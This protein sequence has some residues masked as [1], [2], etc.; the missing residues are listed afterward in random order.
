MYRQLSLFTTQEEEKLMQEVF[1][2][3]Y[4]KASMI[5]KDKVK[6]DGSTGVFLMDDCFLME[7]YGSSLPVLDL[8]DASQVMEH[9]EMIQTGHRF[10]SLEDAYKRF[11]GVMEEYNEKK[12]SIDELK[13]KIRI[14][15]TAMKNNSMQK[16]W[17][18]KENEER[19]ERNHERMKRV[20]Q[21]KKNKEVKNEEVLVLEEKI[22]ELKKT[23]FPHEA[24]LKD[25]LLR[26]EEISESM[27]EISIDVTFSNRVFHPNKYTEAVDEMDEY[28]LRFEELKAI[29]VN[30]DLMIQTID[31]KIK[32]LESELNE[33]KEF[34]KT[35]EEHLQENEEELQKALDERDTGSKLVLKQ[36][37]RTKDAEKKIASMTRKISSIE[38][39]MEAN[40][41]AIIDEISNLILCYVH[42]SKDVS[43]TLCTIK[44]LYEEG[45]P[46]SVEQM[47]V[48]VFTT[49]YAL[50]HSLEENYV[51][52][53][54]M[55]KDAKVSKVQRK[56]FLKFIRVD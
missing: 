50:V 55:A 45:K 11:E 40:K 47:Q 3:L 7:V 1:D 15:Q 23:R 28:K 29:A 14:Q 26:K 6:F 30:E 13:N 8:S 24:R 27:R 9:I 5:M 41:Q 12:A 10:G 46:L 4:R 49:R 48:L 35:L 21:L 38:E 39:E 18:D 19:D 52:H 31:F 51:G 53:V 44:S 32:Q 37:Q 56:Q 33:I 2:D 25:A 34:L 42:E 16:D 36:A 17:I 43:D 54:F 20:N 22:L